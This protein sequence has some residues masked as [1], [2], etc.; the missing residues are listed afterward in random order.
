[1]HHE[2]EWNAFLDALR[3]KASDAL[4][5]SPE[6]R[7]RAERRQE[8]NDMLLLNLTAE[9]R[10]FVLDNLRECEETAAR[11]AA[12]LYRQGWKDSLWLLKTTGL[13]A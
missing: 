11:E 12:A 8:I 2:E 4:A 13:L 7:Y 3:E 1:M 10:A 6:G 9:E 5:S